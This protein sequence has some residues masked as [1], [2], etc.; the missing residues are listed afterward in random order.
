[1][2]DRTDIRSDLEPELEPTEAKTLLGVG[3]RLDRERPVPRPGFRGETGRYLSSEVESAPQ[4]RPRR[5]KL[6][7]A[8][9]AGSGLALLV[10]ALIGVLGAGPLAS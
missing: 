10:V 7:I 3:E 9:Y 4:A 1:M 8:G 2:S 5:L 6:L